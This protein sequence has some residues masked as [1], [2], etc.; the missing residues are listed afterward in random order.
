MSARRLVD[1]LVMMVVLFISCLLVS[2][3]GASTDYK[4]T[5]TGLGH[6]E[7]VNN[8]LTDFLYVDSIAVS[9]SNVFIGASKGND[10]GGAIFL[11][12]DNG[13]NWTQL[14]SG[15]PYEPV[16]LLAVSGSNLYAV[17]FPSG[18]FLSTDSGASWA[19]VDLGLPTDVQNGN[20]TIMVND[21]ASS[22]NTMFAATY[23]GVFR[24]T[25]NGANWTADNAGLTN[26]LSACCFAV[27]G[28]NI[29][30]GTSN[31]NGGGLFESSIDGSSWTKVASTNTGITSL[32]A[33]GSNIFA[34]VDNGG[35]YRSTNDGLTWNNAKSS[36]LP[37]NCDGASPL[38]ASG[39]SIF[40]A[41]CDE[42]VYLSTDN[43][44][45]WAAANS[46]LLNPSVSALAVSGGNIFTG[47]FGG[48]I[49]VSPLP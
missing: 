2:C 33:I 17:L 46:G 9:G 44:T 15:L 37:A 45:S 10:L 4:Y 23:S 29:F 27:S 6:W 12:T 42:G 49:F 19:V 30:V 34:K 13:A 8:G 48:G 7:A 36:G 24:S 26:L 3:S 43:G 11:S 16:Q 35:L 18:V 5:P 40:G 28:G 21:L 47:T 20:A 38:V 1:F 39:N 41:A 22:G 31:D 32:A 14:G 25:D